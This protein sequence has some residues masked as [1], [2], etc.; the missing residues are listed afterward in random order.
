[1]TAKPIHVEGPNGWIVHGLVRQAGKVGGDFCKVLVRAPYLYLLVGD[2]AGKG[3]GAHR[4][5][6]SFYRAF[7][8][9][10]EHQ[11]PS[12]KAVLEGMCAWI[13]EHLGHLQENLTTAV[14]VVV[15]TQTSEFTYANAGHTSSY[16]I[17]HAGPDVEWLEATGFPFGLPEAGTYDERPG[18]LYPGDV[19][20]MYTDGV[21]EVPDETG[22]IFGRSGLLDVLLAALPLPLARQVQMVRRAVGLHRGPKPLPDDLV[23]LGLQQRGESTLMAELPFVIWARYLHVRSATQ[24]LAQA[25]RQW[26]ARFDKNVPDAFFF[27]WELAISEVLTNIVQ[28]AYAHMHGRIQGALL[29][30][31]EKTVLEVWDAGAPFEGKIVERLILEEVV[32]KEEGYGLFLI[33]QSVDQINYQRILERNVWRL[34][35]AW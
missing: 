23:L 25:L 2:V 1:M 24:R 16:L 30:Y 35:K 17:R 9:A 12:A 21:T 5:T 20:W 19:L 28:H 14:V 32:P 18:R 10:V 3:E 26:A 22:H 4:L 13:R 8:H 29:A 6:E 33:R 7:E 34:E 27:H 11:A 31:P 15:D